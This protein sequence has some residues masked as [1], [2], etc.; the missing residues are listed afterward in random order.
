[1]CVISPKVTEPTNEVKG[2]LT[3]VGAHKII[4]KSMNKFHIRL[5]HDVSKGPHYCTTLSGINLVWN[6][7]TFLSFQ[8]STGGGHGT[9]GTYLTC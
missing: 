1:M 4:V 9:S 3:V 2:G 7:L 5:P 6:G 8:N